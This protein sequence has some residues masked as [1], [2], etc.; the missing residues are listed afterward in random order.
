MGHPVVGVL[1]LQGAF[2]KHILLLKA[3]GVETIEVRRSQDL[4]SCDA[5]IIPGGES[6]AIRHQME[7]TGLFPTLKVYAKHHPLFGTCAGLILMS[8]EI[9]ESETTPLGL[10]DISVERNAFG[11]QIDS[12]RA[13]IEVHF[14]PKN[15]QRLSV[16]FIRAP[17]IRR[18]SSDVSILATFEGEPIL[19]RQGH[20]LACTF[21]PELAGATAVHEYFLQFLK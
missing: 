11:R 2:H 14:T 4:E 10:I 5:L 18:V 12:F 17:R 3:L 1:A 9:V 16:F 19:V 20:H 6:T 7:S 15:H 13:E 21:H 8:Q